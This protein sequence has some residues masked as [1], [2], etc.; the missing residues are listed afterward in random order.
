MK[1]INIDDIVVTNKYL[2]LNDDVDT[3]KQSIDTVGLIHPLVINSQNELLAGGR[4][5]SALKE[6]GWSKIP[7]IVAEGSALEQELISIEENMIRQKL[8]SVEFEA[9]LRRAKD[10]YEELFPETKEDLDNPLDEEQVE[11]LVE[12]TGRKPFAM[13]MAEK[14]GS[15]AQAVRTAIKRDI[16]SS[17]K[18]KKARETGDI[19]SAQAS[20]L[21][22]LDKQTQNDLL[23]V[24]VEKNLDSVDT[25]K[26]VSNT[27]EMGA[28]KAIKVLLHADP[29]QKEYAKMAKTFKKMGKDIQRMID[30]QSTFEG[31]ELQKVMAEAEY[32]K[33]MLEEF[34]GQHQ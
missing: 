8:N 13:E 28:D 6:L 17:S 25:K 33:S 5:Y 14:I 31:E 24:V 16:E 10:I 30:I 3:L 21:M 1:M 11:V 32:L 9:C 15:S 2:R 12:H 27:F 23:N 26:L 34:L 4:R 22:K 20:Q 7:V 19:S 18:V 29:A